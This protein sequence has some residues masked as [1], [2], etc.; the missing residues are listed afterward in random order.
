MLPPG[1]G[2]GGSGL[3]PVDSEEAGQHAVRLGANVIFGSVGVLLVEVGRPAEPHAGEGFD[4]ELGVVSPTY[5]CVK[6]PTAS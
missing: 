4:S 1:A 5:V 6:R 3:L 2:G